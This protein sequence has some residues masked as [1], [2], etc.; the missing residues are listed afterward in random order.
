M[1]KVHTALD[2]SLEGWLF[3][4]TRENYWRIAHVREF[5]DIIQDGYEIFAKCRRKYRTS[6][7]N[8]RHFMS[9][10]QRAISNHIS[11]LAHTSPHGFTPRYH[12]RYDGTRRDERPGLDNIEV[13]E[14]KGPTVQNDGPFLRL[15]QEAKFPVSAVLSLFTTDKGLAIL[16]SVPQRHNEP[17][18]HYLARLIGTDPSAYDLPRMVASFLRG[19]GCYFAHM[20]RPI[21]A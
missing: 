6:A 2:S 13:L 10:C 17:L 7:K 3:N 16:D 8:Q 4:F 18:N 21:A 14:F 19:N 9:L 15:L 1:P 5:D 11:L 12:W 20:P